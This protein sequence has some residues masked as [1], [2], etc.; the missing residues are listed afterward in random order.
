[1][2][3]HF[4]PFG[5]AADRKLAF[6]GLGVDADAHAR[7]FEGAL[8]NRVP[9]DDVAVESLVTAFG[10]GAPVVVVRGAPVVPLSVGQFAADADQEQR[11]VFAGRRLLALLGRQRGELLQQLLGLEERDPLGQDGRDVGIKFVNLLLDGLHRL[12]YRFD[13]RFQ[14]AE[15]A[16]FGTHRALPVPL[17]DVERMDVVQLL[18]GADGVHVGVQPVSRGDLVGPEFHALPFGQRVHHLGP[19]VA[20]VADRERHGALHAVQIVVDACA[21]KDEQRGRDAAQAE[22]AGQHVGEN[23]LEIG[24]G[25]LHRFGSELGRIVFRNEKR[26]NSQVWVR[27]KRFIPQ[28]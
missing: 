2:E 16:L 1:M 14:E 6:E 20:Q 9:H 17:V 15:V 5:T 28:I 23:L 10:R 27:E 3:L 19:A 18:V 13:G 7:K 24:D 11:A 25:L 21:R 4:A 26:H 12:V 8:Q 22:A